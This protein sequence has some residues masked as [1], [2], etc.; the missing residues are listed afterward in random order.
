[1][2]GWI[3]TFASF[4]KDYKQIF[5]RRKMESF[6]K[7]VSK[8]DIDDARRYFFR[9]GKGSYKGKFLMSVV[10]GSKVKIR[11]SFELANDLVN[12]VNEIKDLK[13]SGKIL[14]R[15]KIAGKTGRKKG[16]SFIYEVSESSLE[17]FENVYFYLLSV[18]DGDI[19]LKIKKSLPK[20]GKDEDKVDDKFCSL[21]LDLKYW[22]KFKEAFL[23]DVPE[24]KK[25]KISHEVIIERVDIPKEADPAKIRELAKKEGRLIRKIE[26]DGKE[27]VKEYVLEL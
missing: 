22:G 25:V 12:F 1:M 9:F 24:A 13:F 4:Q 2:R 21:D 5:C 20:P 11:T 23:W 3:I 14:S 8:G 26:A 16:A 15:E 18:N 6:L 19:I 17:E 7:K 10:K 27:I